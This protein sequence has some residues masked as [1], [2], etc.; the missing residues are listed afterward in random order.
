MSYA[1]D[2]KGELCR[3]K[4]KSKIE[5][6]LELTS[7]LRLNATV[8]LSSEGVRIRF[9]SEN[10]DVIQRI[11]ALIKYLYQVDLEMQATQNDQLQRVP[12][13][14]AVV[15][16]DLVDRLLA[17]ASLDLVGNYTESAERI[18]A[19]MSGEEKSGA[20]LRGAFLGG[21]TITNPEKGYHLEFNS[22]RSVDA[23]L[24]GMAL[25]NMGVESKS[26]RRKD[27]HVVYMKD[28]QQI[29]E[30]L[31]GVG[32]FQAM[33]RLEDVKAMKDLRND[34]NRKVNAET[35]NMDKSIEASFKQIEAIEKIER[36]IGIEALPESLQAVAWARLENPDVNL[37]EL[38]QLM[39]PK[40]GKSGANHRLKRIVTIA[41]ELDK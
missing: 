20:F 7:I 11:A 26:T 21:G 19:R 36:T 25:G 39:E 18:I 16:G 13:Y 17:D 24:I 32:A 2:T 8:L 29:S 14:S 34:I 28:S 35:A 22:F 5:A 41:D 12:I 3:L 4:I 31:A 10:L 37:R 1:S 15:E 9:L 33:L 6:L 30:F 23:Q 38:G 40:I 27:M